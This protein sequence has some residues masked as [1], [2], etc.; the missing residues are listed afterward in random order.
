[1]TFHESFFESLIITPEEI[2]FNKK[3]RE[4]DNK[5]KYENKLNIEKPKKPIKIKS[6][7]L[8]IICENRRTQQLFDYCKNIDK[9]NINKV[10]F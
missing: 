8:S 2:A 10:T 7:R 9:N 5:I 1:M 3:I 6:H 4:I